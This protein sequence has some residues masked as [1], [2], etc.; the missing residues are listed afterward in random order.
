V[1][2]LAARGQHQDRGRGAGADLPADVEPVHVRQAEVEDDGIE[3]LAV[4]QRQ[5]G[6]ALGGGGD[7][8]A[9]PVEIGLDH[10]GEA[11]VVL[12]EQDAIGHGLTLTDAWHTC[13]DTA[14]DLK[15]ESLDAAGSIG[16]ALTLPTRREA[17]WRGGSA[18][19]VGFTRLGPHLMPNSGRPEFGEAPG[20]GS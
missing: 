20:W 12:D 11:R 16:A 2:R 14:R 10:L 13:L 3:G 8:E 4:L 9:G 6:R 18:A 7:A 19:Q 17:T 5:P 1:D 15:R